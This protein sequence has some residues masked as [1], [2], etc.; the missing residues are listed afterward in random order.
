MVFSSLLFTF[1]FLPLLVVLYYVAENKYRNYILLI[2]SL[3]FYGYGEPKFIFVMLV[4]IIINYGL[5]MGLSHF[6]ELESKRTAK[7][8][9]MLDIVINISILFV[10]KYLNF[11]IRTVNLFAGTSFSL[12]EIALPIGISFFTFQAMSYV[13]DVYRGTVKAQRNPLLL[14]LYI[15]FRS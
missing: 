13:I 11:S 4:S 1:L 2:A 5:A 12:R 3:A 9:L 7:L 8:I 10:F 14:A 6:R 15:S